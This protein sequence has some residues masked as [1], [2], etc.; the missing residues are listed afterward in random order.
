MG[1][2]GGKGMSRRNF[3]KNMGKGA[4]AAGAM[5][6]G[7]MPEAEA[8]EAFDAVREAEAFIQRVTELDTGFDDARGRRSLAIRIETMLDVYAL[9]VNQKQPH[10]SAAG[11]R[12]LQGSVNMQARLSARD[13]LRP[14]LERIVQADAETRDNTA[15]RILR[16]MLNPTPPT[17]SPE[18]QKRMRD[19][20]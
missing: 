5:K 4:V 1:L 13:A 15:I 3:L 9:A 2:E 10:F 16:G 11:S 6:M 20:M 12:S 7:M 8:Q 14:V 19:M 17:L 18:G